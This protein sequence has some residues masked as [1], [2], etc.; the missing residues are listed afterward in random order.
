MTRRHEPF[1]IAPT[2]CF[3]DVVPQR[4]NPETSAN[5]WTYATQHRG[6]IDILILICARRSGNGPRGLGVFPHLL[7]R[8]RD[9]P[10][11][12][13]I[14][15]RL[16]LEYIVT[17]NDDGASPF[18]VR[19]RSRNAGLHEQKDGAIRMTKLSEPTRLAPPQSNP[20]I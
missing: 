11:C 15:N 8:S 12:H 20:L 4:P 16:R 17:V 18:A 13:R 5:V 1:I 6:E 3:D 2:G 10:E 19:Q 7:R 14:I 9:A